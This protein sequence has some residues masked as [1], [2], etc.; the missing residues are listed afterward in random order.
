MHFVY[1]NDVKYT[2]TT[3]IHCVLGGD[4]HTTDTG[5][6]QGWK[7][8]AQRETFLKWNCHLTFNKNV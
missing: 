7:P 1:N 4:R 8:S 6:V 3:G 5:G 2:M